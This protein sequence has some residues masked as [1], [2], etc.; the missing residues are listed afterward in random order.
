MAKSGGTTRHVELELK[1]EAPEPGVSPSFDGLAAVDRLQSPD[2]RPVFRQ[3]QLD[4]VIAALA[5]FAG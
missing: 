2:D 3:E 1:F 4:E 5:S